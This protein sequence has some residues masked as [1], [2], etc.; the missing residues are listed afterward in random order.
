[1]NKNKMFCE[2]FMNKLWTEISFLQQ[3]CNQIANDTNLTNVS[4]GS[5]T[6]VRG[7]YFR[8]NASNSAASSRSGTFSPTYNPKIHLIISP[9]ELFEDQYTSQLRPAEPDFYRPKR[10]IVTGFNTATTS[11]SNF[12]SHFVSISFIKSINISSIFDPFVV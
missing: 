8:L 9:P 10:K 3:L 2:R 7:A 5:L 11:R 4:L 1:M 12:S 6:I